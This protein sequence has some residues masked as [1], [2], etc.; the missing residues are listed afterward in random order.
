[1]K[2]ADWATGKSPELQMNEGFIVRYPYRLFFNGY[3]RSF[4]H[5]HPRNIF[6]IIA[7]SDC[8]KSCHNTFYFFR[9]KNITACSGH[10]VLNLPVVLHLAH[11]RRIMLY[12][13]WFN[14]SPSIRS[15]LR[16]TTDVNEKRRLYRHIQEQALT[17][18]FPAAGNL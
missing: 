9:F 7:L 18:F 17:N 3:Q 13:L 14:K 6:L 11:L 10:L 16:R 5:I 8:W 4:F 2:V 1:M 12:W 15:P